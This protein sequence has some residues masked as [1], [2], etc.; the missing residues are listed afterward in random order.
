MS[1]A[2]G[3]VANIHVGEGDVNGDNMT[4]KRVRLAIISA[5]WP[6]DKC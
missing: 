3:Y 1:I 6:W 4:M 5:V 2:T